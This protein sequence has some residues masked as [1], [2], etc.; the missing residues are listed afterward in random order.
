[1]YYEHLQRVRTSG[2]WEGWLRFFLNGVIHTADQ[3]VKA[4]RAILDL[5]EEDRK[6]LEELGRSAGSAIIVHELLQRRPILSISD[7]TQ[8]LAITRP[9]INAVFQK[10]QELGVLKETTGRQR[11]RLYVYDAYVQ[12]LNEG[13]EP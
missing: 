7:A 1:M 10:M 2:D 13:T 6:K 8:Q 5:F 12:L 11:D 9:T 4:A 3:A